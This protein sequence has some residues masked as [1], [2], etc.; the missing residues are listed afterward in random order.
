MDELDGNICQCDISL[1]VCIIIR[2]LSCE[3]PGG[4]RSYEEHFFGHKHTLSLMF[5]LAYK[6]SVICLFLCGCSC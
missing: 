5:F 4:N 3:M 1:D 2:G 6:T